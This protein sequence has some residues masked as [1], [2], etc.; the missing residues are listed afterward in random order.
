MGAGNAEP[1]MSLCQS[2]EYLP[3]YGNKFQLDAGS[4]TVLGMLKYAAQEDL[5]KSS[6]G[7]SG[8]FKFFNLL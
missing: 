3:Y 4:A 6:K 5:N 2:P 1:L 7:S 8:I